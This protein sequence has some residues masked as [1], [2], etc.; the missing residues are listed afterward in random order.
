MNIGA[1]I[2]AFLALVLFFWFVG[3]LIYAYHV[4]SYG[5][6]GDATKKSTLILILISALIILFATFYFSGIDW[7]AF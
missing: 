1:I 2:I 6:P 5:L 4:I 7:R 3:I